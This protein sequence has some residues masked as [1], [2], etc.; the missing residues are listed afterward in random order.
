MTTFKSLTPNLVVRDIA[1]ST[2]FYTDVIGC[3][4]K[5]TVP[6]TAPFVFVWLERDGVQIF[7]NDAKTVEHELPAAARTIGGGGVFIIVDGLDALH[8]TVAKKTPLAM[9][10]KTQ[11]YGMREFAVSDPDGYV[12]TFAEPVAQR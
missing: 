5:Q 6:D 2:R 4:I 8:E 7:L 9:A 1:A 3:T 10:L 12:V 11:F